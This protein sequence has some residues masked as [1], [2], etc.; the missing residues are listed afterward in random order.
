MVC[1]GI[2]KEFPR[3]RQ[4]R[5]YWSVPR[6]VLVETLGVPHTF[7]GISVAGVTKFRNNRYVSMS[8]VYRVTL[9]ASLK[10]RLAYT[11]EYNI[12]LVVFNNPN[13]RS[14]TLGESLAGSCRN[15]PTL[16]T[17]TTLSIAPPIHLLPWAT[18]ANYIGYHQ[19]QLIT[20][21]AHQ[22]NVTDFSTSFT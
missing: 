7:C 6:E 21:K 4:Q 3:K 9:D 22:Q 17:A 12:S 2:P 5:F 11:P 19:L 15:P 14:K 8:S 13:A 20:R 1:R 10:T 16:T 18:I